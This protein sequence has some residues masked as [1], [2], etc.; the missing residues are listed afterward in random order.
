MTRLES[1]GVVEAVKVWNVKVWSVK[2][3]N[4]AFVMERLLF[5]ASGRLLLAARRPTPLGR[6]CFSPAHTHLTSREAGSEIWIYE[7][8]WKL[9]KER[10]AFPDLQRPQIGYSIIPCPSFVSS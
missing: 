9:R 5:W 4:H 7:D 8:L 10:L 3:W 1:A 6:S 2:V